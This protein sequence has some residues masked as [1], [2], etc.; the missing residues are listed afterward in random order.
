M[1][2]IPND[3]RA[4]RSAELIR[5]GLEECLKEKS[6]PKIRVSDIYEKSFV[7]RATFYR[8]FDC[9]EDIFLYECDAI[10]ADTV[11]IMATKQFGSSN[12]QAIYCIKRWLEHE[13]LMKTMVDNNLF[14]IFWSRTAETRRY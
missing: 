11:R 3:P 4:K 10:R 9:T 2:H 6:L 8:L 7:S 1:Y 12:Q 13:T 14:G 5:M